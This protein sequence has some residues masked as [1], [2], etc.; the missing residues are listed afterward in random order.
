MWLIFMCYFVFFFQLD[1]YFFSKSFLFILIFVLSIL[2]YFPFPYCLSFFNVRDIHTF[3]FLVINYYNHYRMLSVAGELSSDLFK[4]NENSTQVADLFQTNTIFSYL[5]RDFNAS[6]LNNL[7]Q[8]YLVNYNKTRP[9]WQV[10]SSC[11]ME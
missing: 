1:T 6:A 2:Q 10:S 11:I 9:I 5:K 3:P 4:E 8:K 7:I